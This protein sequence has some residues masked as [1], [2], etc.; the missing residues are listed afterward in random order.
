MLAD[1]SRVALSVK[2]RS[3]TLN[4]GVS[5]AGSVCYKRAGC[6]HF[7]S[8]KTKLEKSFCSLTGRHIQSFEGKPTSFFRG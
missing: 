4:S 8:I 7:K 6:S 5:V 3:S 2:N 1:R